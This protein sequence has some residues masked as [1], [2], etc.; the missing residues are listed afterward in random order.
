MNNATYGKR[1]SNGKLE[2]QNQYKT[3]KQRKKLFK[4]YIKTKLYVAQSI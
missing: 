2:K 1:K 3:R 4:M